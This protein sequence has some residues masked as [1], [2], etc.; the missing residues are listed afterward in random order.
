MKRSFF[1]SFREIKSI[2]H[3]GRKRVNQIIDNRLNCKL[4][5]LTNRENIFSKINFLT[6]NFKQKFSNKKTFRK[7]RFFNTKERFFGPF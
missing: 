1:H 5:T 7:K 6:E 4:A 3:G 2:F